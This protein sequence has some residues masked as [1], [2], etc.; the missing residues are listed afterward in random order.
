MAVVASSECAALPGPADNARPPY[1]GVDRMRFS[2]LVVFSVTVGST[3]AAVGCTVEQREYSD[4]DSAPDSSAVTASDASLGNRDGS[5]ADA[6]AADGGLPLDRDSGKTDSGNPPETDGATPECVTKSDCDDQNV[7][8]GS[9]I[10][11]EGQCFSD[12]QK[13]DD[14]ESCGADDASLVC[15]VGSCVASRCGDGLPAFDG[16]EECDDA[17]D[18]SNDGCEENCKF[19]CSTASDCP[20][21]PACRENPTCEEHICV[22]G[23]PAEDLTECGTGTVCFSGNCVAEGCG[24]GQVEGDEECD[25]G[26]A[27]ANDGCTPKCTYSC[28]ENAECDNLNVCDGVETC[29]VGNHVCVAG[30]IPTCDDRDDCTVDSCD[31]TTGC[32][33][34]PLDEDGDGHSPDANG[35]G[36]DC[37]DTNET[38]YTG[39]PELCDKVDNDC[40][41]RV[42]EKALN[43]Y[44][45]CDGDGFAV[46]GSIPQTGCEMPPAPECKAGL[47]STWTTRVPSSAGESDCW[48][49]DPNVH[50]R[51]TAEDAL[52]WSSK[53]ISGR[54]VGEDFDY[55]CVSGNEPRWTNTGVSKSASCGSSLGVG[56]LTLASPLELSQGYDFAQLIDPGTGLIQLCLG[57]AGWTA[58]SAPAC[59]R[60]GSYTNCSNASGTCER[61]TASK[62]Q[63]CR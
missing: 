50:P 20:A 3:F 44:V 31:P 5:I 11:F 15:V 62:P 49:T 23:S 51:T 26:N 18:V 57:S 36:D 54:S 56:S 35:C 52:A 17:N 19:S 1:L 53:E 22:V 4:T 42:D 13:L 46:L 32:V 10:C 24:N 59:G 9:Q 33:T 40:N 34:A 39:A 2:K 37:D 27:I 58:A 21:A 60:S 7:C 63:E 28:T 47:A 43:W 14:G 16:S 29:D 6:A 12:N 61:V 55:N 45:D 48:D 38:V 30:E 25:D 8:N 41:E